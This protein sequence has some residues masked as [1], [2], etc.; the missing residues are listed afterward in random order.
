MPHLIRL[1]VLPVALFAASPAAAYIG[2][3]MGAGTIALVLG[4]L[5][6]IVM[7]FLALLWY[8]LKRMLKARK[9]KS[10]GPDK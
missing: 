10:A 3:G 8:P 9:A 6:A 1:A 2:P 4:I 7:A 5:A